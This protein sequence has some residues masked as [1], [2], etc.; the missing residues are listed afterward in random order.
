VRLAAALLLLIVLFAIVPR[1]LDTQIWVLFSAVRDLG[2]LAGWRCAESA[3]Y[4]YDPRHDRPDPTLLADAPEAEVRARAPSF[5]V[6]RVEVNLRGGDT[7]VSV[8]ADAESGFAERRVYVL[9]PG[10]LQTITV[11]QANLCNV[12]LG[13]W[14]IVGEHELG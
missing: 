14:R 2:P 5:E 7:L 10:R 13:D 3:S 6:D 1:V 8:H 9:S 12:H 11:D 4:V